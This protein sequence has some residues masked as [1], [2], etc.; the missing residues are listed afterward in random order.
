M[1]LH[2]VDT[3]GKTRAGSGGFSLVEIVVG[4]GILGLVAVVFGLMAI[5]QSQLGRRE[6]DMAA[7]YGYA[8]EL[9]ERLALR[10][11]SVTTFSSVTSQGYAYPKV[12][13]KGLSSRDDTRFVTKVEVVDV[14]AD[15]K[16]ATVSL[17]QALP[18]VG[19]AAPPVAPDSSKPRK[20]EV[21]RMTCVFNQ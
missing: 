16:M 18:R 21:L 5:K 15:M 2:R 8:E 6:I 14:S 20:G 11:S 19:S 4:V 17:W 3:R 12:T 13:E 9:M 1:T 10:A 7:A